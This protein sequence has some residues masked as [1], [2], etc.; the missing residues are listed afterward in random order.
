MNEARAGVVRWNININPI[1]NA[2]NTASAIGIPGI[3]I[4]NHAGR[5]AGAFHHRLP[6][7][8]DNST[9]PEFSQ[10]TLF[11]YED[12]LTWFAA[13]TPSSSAAAFIRDR[14]NGFSAFPTRG[15]Y[16]FN[17]Q[18]TRQTGASTSVTALSDFALGAPSDATRNIL[19]GEFGMRFWNLNT[20]A[21]DT[22]RVTNRLTLNYGLRYEVNAPPYDVHNHW[23]NFN[24]ITGQLRAGR[25]ERQQ[26][27]ACAT[28]IPA[29]FE[30]RV[31]VAY[32]L[33]SDQ[34]TV[35]RTASASP[36]WSPGKG[37]GQLY[38]NLP[39]FFSQTITTDQ[40]GVPPLYLRKACPRRCSPI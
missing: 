12:N 20:F 19:E 15:S 8:G 18:F 1:G 17:G 31:G 40:N 35:L 7:V 22:W 29:A 28:S 11:Q 4:N 33:T 32:M 39:Y 36:T 30:P 24:L 23:S 21:Q 6:G 10:M 38:K 25:A 9:Y 27:H 14:F 37:G 2:F 34:K 26:P 16:T 13:I 5:I 3:N